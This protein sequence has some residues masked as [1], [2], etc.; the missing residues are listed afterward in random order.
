M[1]LQRVPK[2]TDFPLFM[3]GE[4]VE[5]EAYTFSAPFQYEMCFSEWLKSF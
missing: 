5:D 3:S 2:S 1:K 4:G